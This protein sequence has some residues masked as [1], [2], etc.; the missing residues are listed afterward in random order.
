MTNNV[1]L[2]FPIDFD[3]LKLSPILGAYR[4]LSGDNFNRNI[5]YSSKIKLL[6]VDNDL[7]AICIFLDEFKDSEKT[8]R[9]YTKELERLVLWCIH[10]VKTPI[11]SLRRSDLTNY[12]E[13]LKNPAPKELWCGPKTNRFFTDNSSPNPAWRAFCSGLSPTTLNK[14]V[15]ILDSFFNYL[16]EMN[17]L[18][19]NPFALN[20]RRKR[21][22]NAQSKIV[23]RYLELDEIR[24]V[25]ESLD[26]QAAN[27]ETEAFQILRARYII[28]LLFYSGLRI[29]EASTHSMGDYFQREN[30]WFL[31]VLGKGKKTRDIP[32]PDALLRALEEFRMAVGLNSRHPEFKESTPLIPMKNLNQ[33]ITD[34]RINQILKWAFNLG[35]IELESEYPNKASKLRAASAHWLRHSYVTYLL[36]M[37]APLKVAQENAGHADISTTLIYQHIAQIDRYDA[38]KHLNLGIYKNAD[39]R[40][41]E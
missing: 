29:T 37:G 3:N 31:R 1:D 15:S 10:I 5:E 38:S 17:Y 13:F 24:A 12:L 4:N 32:I 21:T 41:T 27:K 2:I 19:G 20:K 22:K 6:E 11:S 25:L 40:S 23:D 7:D 33:P 9:S 35:A 36:E 39:V 8:W 14:T 28:L 30:N 16:V 18:L 34:R 26:K